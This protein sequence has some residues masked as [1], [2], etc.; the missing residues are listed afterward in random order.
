M[1]NLLT[2]IFALLISTTALAEKYALIVAV[3]DYVPETGWGKISSANDVPII[4]QA[5]ISQAFKL[6]YIYKIIDADATKVGILNKIKEIQSLLKKGDILVV[7]FSMHGQQ[8]F[9]DNGDEIDDLDESIVPYDANVEYTDNYKGEN[10][11]RDDELGNIITNLRNTLGED[12]QL[13]FLL[14]SCH[15]GSSTRGGAKA[16]GGKAALTPEGWT[17]GKNPNALAGDMFQRVKKDPDT[18]PFVMISGASAAELNYEYQGNGSLSYAFA[19]ALTSLGSDYTYRQLFS[20]IAAQMNIISPRQKPTIEGDQDYKLFKGEYVQQQPYYTLKRIARPDLIQIN[21]GEIQQLFKGTTINIVPAGTT[22][23]SEEVVVAKG[24]VIK[25]AF[26]TANVTLDKPL[27]SSNEKEFWVFVDEPSYGDMYLKAYLYNVTDS[28]ISKGVNTYLTENNLG[29]VVTEIDSA[30]V[31]IRPQIDSQKKTIG[32]AVL[33]PSGLSEIDKAIASRGDSQLDALEKQLFQYAQGSYIRDLTMTNPLYEFEFK[34]VPVDYDEEME[35]VN[36]VLPAQNEG[37]EGV[38]KV[39]TNG[40]YA[41][42]EVTNKSNK[43]LYF[44]I[45]EIN[46]KGEIAQFLPNDNYELAVD[47]LKIPKGKTMLLDEYVFAFG[48]PYERLTLKGFATTTPINLKPIITSRGA[49]SRGDMNPLE[50]FV[51]ESYSQTRGG[52]ARKT[53]GKMRGYTTEF[54]YEIVEK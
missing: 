19:K 15:S 32:Y 14:D 43:D 2:V 1:K 18:A 48:P 39:T 25:T 11:I 16:R 27:I 53:G 4:E 44:T 45:I 41:A 54:V 46:S 40:D 31:I 47:D 28:Q 7:H 20:K 26:S 6:E 22:Q 12:G 29:E 17:P 33:N 52:D 24:K 35:V 42:I 10:H 9:D 50:K 38:Y 37:T 13:L 49:T 51:Q 23:F 36:G 3:G 30:T 34:L 21:G 8:L 5:L